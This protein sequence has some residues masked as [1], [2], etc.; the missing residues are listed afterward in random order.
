MQKLG[1]NEKNEQEDKTSA[2]ISRSLIEPV[3]NNEKEG[4]EA[5]KPKKPSKYESFN[6]DKK[7]PNDTPFLTHYKR[8]Q[9]QMKTIE[10]SIKDREKEDAKSDRDSLLK[11]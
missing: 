5:E 7:A 2:D 4:D 8:P 11:F 6:A 9:G 10:E 3:V 1:E